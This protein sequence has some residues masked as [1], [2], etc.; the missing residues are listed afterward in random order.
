MIWITLSLVWWSSALLGPSAASLLHHVVIL[1]DLGL[2]GEELLV[3]ARHLESPLVGLRRHFVASSEVLPVVSRLF[4]LGWTWLVVTEVDGGAEWRVHHV[5]DGVLVVVFFVDFLDC[6]WSIH[7]IRLRPSKS[8]QFDRVSLPLLAY[9]FL[10]RIGLANMCR[11]KLGGLEMQLLVPLARDAALPALRGE[12]LVGR[13]LVSA[14][15]VRCLVL[16]VVLVQDSSLVSRA[17]SSADQASQAVLRLLLPLC[18]LCLASLRLEV[19]KLL[20]RLVNSVSMA[21]DVVVVH[22]LEI[23]HESLLGRELVVHLVLERG[24]RSLGRLQ[25]VESLLFSHSLQPIQV[26]NLLLKFGPSHF[27]N[28][29]DRVVLWDH[30]A[31]WDHRCGLAAVA[32]VTHDVLQAVK[33]KLPLEVVRLVEQ[34]AHN[35]DYVGNLKDHQDQGHGLDGAPFFFSASFSRHRLTARRPDVLE[36]VSL[37]KDE[38]AERYGPAKADQDEE[39]RG[40]AVAR[41]DA[42]DVVSA[43]LSEPEKDVEDRGQDL[44]GGRDGEEQDFEVVVRLLHLVVVASGV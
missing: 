4:L 43:A 40:A 5:L 2:I 28:L 37:Q 20:V 11:G 32:A 3:C 31:I 13:F 15:H 30:A 10:A 16:A 9:G 39:A 38:D 14:Q 44:D 12:D 22:G 33:V 25:V 42:L 23:S 8:S 7:V 18:F 1:V 36:V 21:A 26:V 41:V 17:S 24:F 27:L 6:V 34:T 19:H 35:A 29:L